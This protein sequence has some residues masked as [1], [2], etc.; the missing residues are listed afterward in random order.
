MLI[1]IL[2]NFFEYTDKDKLF[3]DLSFSDLDLGND[4]NI[5]LKTP[6][7]AENGSIVPIQIESFLDGEQTFTCSPRK[8]KTH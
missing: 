4:K 2:K 3:D 7:I 1:K 6:D 5:N 8:M